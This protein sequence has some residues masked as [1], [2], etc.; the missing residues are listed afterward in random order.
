MGLNMS[1]RQISQELGV[2]EKTAQAMADKLRK[3]VQKNNPKP[4][5]SGE[6]EFDEVYIVAGHKGH[7]EAVKKGSNRQE[8]AFERRAWSWHFGKRKA[9]CF[10]HDP[11]RRRR[12]YSHA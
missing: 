10:G 9:A 5:L 8:K 11:T 12:G 7:P 4:T 3:E 2:S 6:V 1:N